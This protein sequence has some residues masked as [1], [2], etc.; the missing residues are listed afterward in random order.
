MGGLETSQESAATKQRVKD[1][2]A[3]VRMVGNSMAYL[4]ALTPLPPW[5]NMTWSEGNRLKLP[6][7]SFL[8]LGMEGNS[9]NL[10]ATFWPFCG[11]PMG[12]I[13]VLI[14]SKLRQKWQHRQDLRLEATKICGRQHAREPCRETAD[15]QMPGGRRLWAEEYKWNL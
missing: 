9:W 7:S 12:M 11:L 15:L 8:P 6:D 14:D 10:L 3:T 13:S 2:K 1:E 4:L 5:S